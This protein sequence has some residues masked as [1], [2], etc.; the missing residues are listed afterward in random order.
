M[1]YVETLKNTEQQTELFE[2]KSTLERCR[3]ELATKT[4]I[5]TKGNKNRSYRLVIE[6]LKK[7]GIIFISVGDW[8]YKRIEHCTKEEIE[9]Y[10]RIEITKIASSYF[11]NIKK[12][13]DY[14]KQTSTDEIYFKTLEELLGGE[15]NDEKLD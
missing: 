8:L 3:E 9:R 10:Y 5:Y 15:Y 14:M 6:E 2:R 1:N 11:N 13:Q 12:V 4:S 7:Q